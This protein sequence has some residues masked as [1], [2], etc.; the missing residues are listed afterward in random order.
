MT[1]PS[2]P[3]TDPEKAARYTAALDEDLA[4]VA[5]LRKARRWRG[6]ASRLLKAASAAGKVADKEGA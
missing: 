4:A 1:A 5:H 6:L 2:K 3:M